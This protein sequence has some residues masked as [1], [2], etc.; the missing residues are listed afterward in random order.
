MP[1]IYPS[2][3]FITRAPSCSCIFIPLSCHYT[4]IHSLTCQ[5]SKNK[6]RNIKSERTLAQLFAQAEGP[7]SSER[8][9]RSGELPSP[10]R[11]LDTRNS[12]L[13]AFSLKRVSPRLSE[14][15]AHLKLSWSPERPFT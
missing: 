10:R 6:K 13:H 12:S 9:S 7:R 2:S 11:K 4:T 5:T 1:R 8:V 15:L 3:S 14:T